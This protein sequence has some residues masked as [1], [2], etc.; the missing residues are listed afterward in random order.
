[1]DLSGKN[2]T[3][4]RFI[5]NTAGSAVSLLMVNAALAL[6]TLADSKMADRP[7]QG[8]RVGSPMTIPHNLGD[9]W[10]AAWGDDDNL[11]SPSNDTTGFHG[12][13]L[14]TLLT[15]EQQKQR[16]R[17][18][19]CF[20][21]T[22]DQKK[23]LA[24]QR[25]SKI[26]FNRIK[27]AEPGTLDGITVNWMPDYKMQDHVTERLWPTGVREWEGADGRTWKSSGCASIDGV[28]YWAI[29]RHKYGEISGDA[30][31]RQTAVNASIIKSTDFGLNWSRSSEE[32]LKKPMFPGSH[33]ATPYFID[34]G[35]IRQSV[36]GSDQYVYAI[37]NNGF[38]DNGDSLILGRVLRSRMRE[39]N[40]GDWEF[41]AGQ[42]GLKETHWTRNAER[43]KPILQKP[44]QLGET[45]AV[46][47]PARRRYIMI[48][49]YYPSGSGKIKGASSTTVWDFYEA[50]RPW[51]PWTHIDS[52]TFSPQGYYCPGICPKFQ[53]TS[54]VYALTAGDFN[55]G[56][57]FYHLTVVPINLR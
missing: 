7:I 34:Y 52:H 44:G 39:L 8:I 11:Y 56:W 21:F 33:F 32:N 23:K 26:A 9:T 25:H 37:A 57:D 53:T 6:E 43:A 19:A 42:D 14:D 18:P 3:R 38:W 16:S 55:N 35:K 22:A 1:M 54:T 12:I 4:R 46:Y 31:L 24:S 30:S 51:G 5:A 2:L 27:G 40:G 45:G 47:L 29:S 41:L 48:G 17:D 50:P 10:A 15:P 36:D 20:K 28:L 49:W 13:D